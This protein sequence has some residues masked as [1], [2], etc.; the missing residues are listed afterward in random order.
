MRLHQKC[1]CTVEVNALRLHIREE[2][3]KH[4]VCRSVIS[5]DL[6]ACTVIMLD[7]ANLMPVMVRSLTVITVCF[8][9]PLVPPES[10]CIS[11]QINVLYQSLNLNK[12]YNNTH[13]P[14]TVQ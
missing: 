11:L 1:L 13:G 5:S 6:Q 9:T 10:S 8:G 12:I 14:L 3:G 2:I 7:V 4:N